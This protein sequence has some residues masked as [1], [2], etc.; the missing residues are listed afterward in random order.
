MGRVHGWIGSKYTGW[1]DRQFFT[2]KF[3]DTVRHIRELDIRDKKVVFTN[4][5]ECLFSRK[6]KNDLVRLLDLDLQT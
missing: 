5:E 3:M 6:V 1:P 2:V 4:G